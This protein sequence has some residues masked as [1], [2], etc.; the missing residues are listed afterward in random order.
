VRPLVGEGQRAIAGE[1]VLADARDA[2]G[3]RQFVPL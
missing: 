1:T 2:S 3:A